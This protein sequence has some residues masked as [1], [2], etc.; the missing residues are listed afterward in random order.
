MATN[1]RKQAWI[2]INIINKEYFSVRWDIGALMEE[3]LNPKLME[4]LVS[5]KQA[6]IQET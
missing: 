3:L 5:A 2:N 1:L 4:N 6:S